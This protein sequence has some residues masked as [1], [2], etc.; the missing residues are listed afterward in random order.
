ML[1]FVISSAKD[2]HVVLVVL[3]LQTRE[4]V[5]SRWVHVILVM[6]ASILLHDDWF[7]LTIL[8]TNVEIMV[9]TAMPLPTAGY[10]VCLCIPLDLYVNVLHSFY[11]VSSL[12]L[13]FQ[14]C[15]GSVENHTRNFS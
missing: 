1:F 8:D 11:F 4:L 9:P 5:S 2:K 15:I 13:L 10:P 12:C 14:P 7:D 3:N 6:H